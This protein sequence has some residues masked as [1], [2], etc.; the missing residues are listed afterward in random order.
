MPYKDLDV[1]VGR[2]RLEHS[3]TANETIAT[4]GL[5]HG[6]LVYGAGCHS[7]GDQRRR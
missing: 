7:H 3:M 4:S 6:E 2:E 5:V 1:T